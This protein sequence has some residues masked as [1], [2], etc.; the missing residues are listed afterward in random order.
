M[1]SPSNIIPL[2]SSNLYQSNAT[3]WQHNGTVA[4]EPDYILVRVPVVN[5]VP[6]YTFTPS[7]ASQY[8][9][10]SS[11]SMA[12]N[13]DPIEQDESDSKPGIRRTVV[14]LP[15]V[16]AILTIVA[17]ALAFTVSYPKYDSFFSGMFMAIMAGFATVFAFYQIPASF[18]G[19]TTLRVAF[20]MAIPLAVIY[21]ALPIV[22]M[23][24]AYD[25][26]SG[27]V[28]LV[29]FGLHVAWIV[30]TG[31]HLKRLTCC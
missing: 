11:T 15:I 17:W 22:G 3:N 1:S 24:L 29:I 13:E 16:N 18:I 6:Q 20:W 19:G 30:V 12:A 25:F 8:Q 28:G 5:G 2:E 4:Q 7:G 10:Q 23:S 14:A 27:P 31:I 21:F 9:Y 26:G